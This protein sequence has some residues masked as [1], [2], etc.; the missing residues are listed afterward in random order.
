MLLS[1]PS[2]TKEEKKNMQMMASVNEELEVDGQSSEDTDDESPDQP[3]PLNVTVPEYRRRIISRL[4]GELDR[5]IKDVTL[6]RSRQAGTHRS[7]LRPTRIRC[8][9]NVISGNTV[10]HSL[11][12]SYYHSRYL[13]SLTPDVLTVVGPRSDPNTTIFDRYAARYADSDAMDEDEED[14]EEDL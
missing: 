14:A 13:E 12:R 5:K 9:S 2:L 6:R 3:A 8:R 7:Q 4:M 10:K 11:P 1:E